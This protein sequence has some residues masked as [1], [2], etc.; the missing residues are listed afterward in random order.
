MDNGME[1]VDELCEDEEN[2][3]GTSNY[4]EVYIFKIIYFIEIGNKWFRNAK[5]PR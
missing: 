3:V 5:H 2:C 1:E 4:S